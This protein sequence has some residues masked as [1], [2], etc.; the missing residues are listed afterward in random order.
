M[1]A[2]RANSGHAYRPNQGGPSARAEIDSGAGCGAAEW[3]S[4]EVI[5][6]ADGV[7]HRRR[8]LCTAGTKRGAWSDR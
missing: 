7:E 5:A 4:S 1:A 2:A 8:I 6:S 3:V